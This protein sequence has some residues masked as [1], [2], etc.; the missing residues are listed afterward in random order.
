[1]TD[2]RFRLCFRITE[3]DEGKTV[4][5]FLRAKNISRAALTDIKFRGGN[6]SVNGQDVTVRK[7]LQAGECL[8]V[9]FPEEKPSGEMAAEDIPLP[10]LY[11]DDYVL[12]VNK[13]AGMNTIPSREHPRGSL[14]NA[15]SGY[16]RKTGLS[17]AVHIVT[18]LDRNTS[19]IVLIAKYRHIH[20]LFSQQ[21][22]EGW[23]IRTYEALAEGVFS[24]SRGWIEEPIA[25]KS[26]S[27][28]EREVNPNGQYACTYFE[29]VRQY[30]SYAHVRI[31]PKTGRTHQ[32]RVHLAH[33]GH[34]LLGDDLYG[35]SLKL[36]NRQALHCS[37]IKF[38]H[39]VLEKELEFL[40]SLPDD[41]KKL[42]DI[43]KE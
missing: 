15:V 13:P 14:A 37:A 25:R 27:I 12:V 34:P 19:G 38:F 1:M 41:M 23:I 5:E 36:I 9:T 26:D 28:I 17:S 16:Y 24:E 6:L 11:E 31:R 8:A 10:I 22:R 33:L 32:I 43:D 40:A 35:G 18:R 39:P 29:L 20:H 42:T 2:K 3:E 4:R 30:R 7:I 21:Q